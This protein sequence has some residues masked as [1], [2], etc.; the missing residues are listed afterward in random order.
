MMNKASFIKWNN[1]NLIFNMNI[2][3]EL[4]NEYREFVNVNNED[5]YSRAVVKAMHIFGRE[6]DEG[7]T[8][9]EAEEKVLSCNEELGG[10]S[11]EQFRGMISSI[12]HFHERAD[13]VE[14]WWAEKTAV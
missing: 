2:P 8:P 14:K 3:P 4:V 5:D 12:V 6:L 11:G 13:E 10:L 7:K 9:D 1:V